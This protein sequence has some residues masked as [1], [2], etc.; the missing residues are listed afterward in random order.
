MRSRRAIRRAAVWGISWG[1]AVTLFTPFS[2]FPP[3]ALGSVQLLLWWLVYF[4]APLWCALGCLFVWA[5]EQGERVAGVRGI[6]AAWLIVSVLGAVLLPILSFTLTYLTRGMF[7]DRRFATQFGLPALTWNVTAVCDLVTF[8]LWTTLFFGGLLATTYTLT[9][10][11]ERTRAL[12]HEVAMSRNRT[13]EMLDAARLEALEQ[14]I[15]PNLL[16]QCMQELEQR[17]RVDPDGAERL[18]EALVEFLRCAMRGLRERV[19]T[20]KT[21]LHLAKAYAL[22]QCERGVAGVW[23]IEPEPLP[24]TPIPFPSLLMLRL[25]ALGGE[26]ERPTLRT[27]AE[28]GAVRMSLV[29][30]AC[31]AS[32]ELRQSLCARL[33]GLYGE[34]FRLECSPAAGMLA[35]SLDCVA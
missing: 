12:L 13:E 15:D 26:A 27:A 18:L 10:R 16:L 32:T 11:A 6:L 4:A 20:L 8:G 23:Q 29:G 2:A 33:R 9:N 17:Y 5:V 7:V 22:L 35:I 25:L 28:G 31:G 34:R 19:S 30:L 14:Q 21:E 3:E 1:L 24:V